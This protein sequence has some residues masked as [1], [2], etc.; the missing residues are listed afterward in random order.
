LA[1]VYSI[2][3]KDYNNQL[4]DDDKCTL[5]NDHWGNPESRKQK[6]TV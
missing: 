5:T 6:L 1:P 3:P 4:D 2:T